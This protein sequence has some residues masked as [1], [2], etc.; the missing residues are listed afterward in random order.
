MLS[1]RFRNNV[2]GLGSVAT[3]DDSTNIKGAPP[4]LRRNNRRHFSTLFS[5]GV[6]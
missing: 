2:K 1:L 6:G 3:N 4:H 5:S